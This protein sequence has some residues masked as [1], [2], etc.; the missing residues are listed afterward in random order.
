MPERDLTIISGPAVRQI[1]EDDDL[2]LR[3]VTD[4]YLAHAR[5]QTQTPGTQPLYANG[6]RFFAMPASIE[7][8]RP[9]IGVKWVA[10]FVRNVSAGAE[11]AAAMLIV[12]DA[13]TGKPVASR[14][15]VDGY[16]FT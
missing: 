6:G 3:A 8:E 9:I 5:G 11:R 10:S 13:M 4:A 16:V 14:E 2:V 1:L 7:D 12:N 15:A